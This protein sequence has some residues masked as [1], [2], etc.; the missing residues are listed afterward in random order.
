[1][2]FLSSGS[3]RRCAR[4][5]RSRCSG[6]STL[7]GLSLSLSPCADDVP[8]DGA[9]SAEFPACIC[10]STPIRPDQ[11]LAPATPTAATGVTRLC[12]CEH[13]TQLTP[14]VAAPTAAAN[15]AGIPSISPARDQNTG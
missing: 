4:M 3:L 10:S 8:G 5:N 6:A 14:L 11:T 1:M 15:T 7:A 2:A 9:K 12:E 13:P